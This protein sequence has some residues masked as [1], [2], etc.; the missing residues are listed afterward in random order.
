MSMWLC[1]WSEFWREDTV[2]LKCDYQAS[3]ACHCRK[4]WLALSIPISI[5]GCLIQEWPS[6]GKDLTNSNVVIS[7]K[8]IKKMIMF[9]ET[10]TSC[11]CWVTQNTIWDHCQC[12][13]ILQE[14]GLL[15]NSWTK[16]SDITHDR[17][18]I[19]LKITK[20]SMQWHLLNIEAKC[21]MSANLPTCQIDTSQG[22]TIFCTLT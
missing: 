12:M 10:D 7:F 20:D 8:S 22:S 3:K 9:E 2:Q 6:L 21:S 13:D 15:E 19:S 4:E 16:T 11:V 14:K 5:Y 17:T 1:S 18:F